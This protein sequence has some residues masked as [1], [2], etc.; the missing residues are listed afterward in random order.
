MALTLTSDHGYVLA[1]SLA[2]P[3]HCMMQG[4]AVAKVRYRVFDD[5]YIEANL[6]EENNELKAAGKAPISKGCHPDNGLGRLSKYLPIADWLDLQQA[7][8][9]HLNYLESISLT[10]AGLAVSGY[11]YPKAASALAV[12]HLIGRQLFCSGMRDAPEKRAVGFGITFLTNLGFFGLGM[13]GCV[14]MTGIIGK[15]TGK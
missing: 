12:L 5:K 14:K 6:Q 2:I 15:L 7:Q 13:Y 8:R 10:Q 11:F 4:F 1:A 3:F 9:A